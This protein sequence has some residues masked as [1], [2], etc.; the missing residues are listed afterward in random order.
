MN[1]PPSCQNYQERAIQFPCLGVSLLGI[2]CEPRSTLVRHPTAVLIIVGGPQYRAGSH[3]QFT[4][5]ARSLAENGITSLRMDY[6]GMGDSDGSPHTFEEVS[7]DVKS[8]IDALCQNTQGPIERLVLWGLCD[9]ASAALL[10]CQTKA[11]PRVQGLVLL[12]PWVRSGHSLAKTHI[13]HYYLQRLKQPAFWKKFLSGG[14]A[15][16]ALTDL[17]TTARTAFGGKSS[18]TNA[19]AKH[20]AWHAETLAQ[21][22]APFQDRMALAWRHFS[23][24]ILLLTSGKDLTAQE[25]LD[26]A[27]V[28][29][30]WKNLL[31]RTSVRKIDIADADHTFSNARH[32]AEVET[33]TAEFVQSV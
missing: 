19:N 17:F 1:V 28:T 25:F 21:S 33:Y 5:L 7:D 12:N 15:V 13:K 23:G 14:V 31:D 24:Q 16:S 8:A 30:A 26:H 10:Y 6:R 20:N 2:I 22:T 9:G 27:K 32:R 18:Q 3:R 11:D 29:P 4:L